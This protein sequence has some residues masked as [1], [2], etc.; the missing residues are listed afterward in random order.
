MA[1]R[2]PFTVIGGFLGAGKTTLLNH[3]L[4]SHSGRRVAVLVN[5]F[6]A[7]NI[8]ASLIDV[9][10]GETIALTNGCVC[11]SIGGDLSSALI[12]VL[13][14]HPPFEAIVVEASGVS[15]PGRIARLAQAAPELQSDG[16]VVV[17]DSSNVREQLQDPQLVDTLLAQ[18]RSADLLVLN[19]V[20]LVNPEDMPPILERLSQLAPHTPTVQTIQS[21]LAWP[22]LTSAGLHVAAAESCGG[23]HGS[24]DGRVEAHTHHEAVF[25]AWSSVPRLVLS[26]SAWRERLEKL[27]RSVL[28]LKGYVP[29]L[30]HGWCEVQLVGRRLSLHPVTNSHMPAEGSLVAIG[31]QGQLPRHQLDTLCE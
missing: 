21:T 30:E 23:C 24:E 26:A 11:C 1:S 9:T 14:T 31:V 28:R 19:K 12:Q 2:I 7:M 6:G 17:V 22:L 3:L 25:E 20:D 29:S 18:L 4:R 10:D 27:P 8:D 16:V 13:E 5:D 15:D